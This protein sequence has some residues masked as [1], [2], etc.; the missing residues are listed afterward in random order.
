M[1]IVEHFFALIAPHTCKGCG[2]EGSVLCGGCMSVLPALPSRCYRCNRVT[3]EYRTCKG[4]R[5]RSALFA[6]F[7]CTPYTDRAKDVLHALKYER[8]QAAAE[9]VAVAIAGRMPFEGDNYIIT[10]VPTVAARVRAR[11]YDQA[12]LIARE[13]SGITG[14]PYTP[15]LARMGEGRQVGQT[16]A[17]RQQ[18][19]QRAFYAV[20]V[21]MVQKRHILLVDDVLTTGATCEA[22]ARTLCQAGAK[23]VSA[24]V[25]AAA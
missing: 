9:D 2:A 20:Q 1:W 14:I 22:A 6:A 24:V 13:F 10:H 21:P 25:F 5:G 17:M 16:R 8:A 19:M 11:G 23:R 7:V 15:L 18:Q 4:C 12:A 3:Q